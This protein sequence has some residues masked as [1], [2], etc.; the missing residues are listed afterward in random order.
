[1]TLF[2]IFLKKHKIILFMKQTFKYGGIPNLWWLGRMSPI[3]VFGTKSHDSARWVWAHGHPRGS[4]Y[5]STK[6][7]KNRKCSTRTTKSS[8]FFQIC[9]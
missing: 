5:L 2:F 1:M 7:N 4:T 3:K 9:D 8:Y 6:S